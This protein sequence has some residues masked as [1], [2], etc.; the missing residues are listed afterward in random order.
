MHKTLQAI[1][2][3]PRLRKIIDKI[4]ENKRISLAVIFGSYAKGTATKQSDIDLYIETEDRKIK[5]LAELIDTKL[6]VK[7]GLYDRK[8]ILIKEIEKD[9]IIIKGVEKFYEKNEFFE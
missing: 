1:K 5:E 8:N 2:K 3:Y 9:H 7:T 4:K 6:S